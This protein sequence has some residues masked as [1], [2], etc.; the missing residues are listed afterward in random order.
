MVRRAAAAA[1]LFLFASAPAPLAAQY[2][3]QNKVQ[4]STFDFK[5]IQTDHF[6]VHYYPEERAAALD[7]ARMAERAYARLSRVLNHQFRER[8]PIIVYASH[9]DFQQTNATP[10]EVGEGTGGFTD[11]L[12]HRNIFPLTGSYY[13][14]EHVLM[15]EMVHQFQYDVWSRGRAGGGLATI[16]A[17]NPPLWFVEGMAEYLSI[18]PVDPNTAMWLRDA[19]IRGKVP[20]VEQLTGD[21]RI[22]PYRFGHALIAYIGERWG[23]EAVGAILTGT[24]S[25]GLEASVR[26]TL[27][28]SLEQLSE[29]WRDAVNR[30]YLPEIGRHAK[31][32]AIA[33]PLLT[34]ERSK[35]TLHLAP[36]LSPDGSAVAYFGEGDSYFVDLWL[37]DSTGATKRRLFKSTFSGDYETF[38]FLNSQAAWSP[39]GKYLAFAG[40][41]GATDEII[42]LDVARN[43]RVG[44]IRLDL[45]GV[46][47][48]TWSPDGERLVFTG[49]E[50]GLSDLF[51]VGRDGQGLR[52]LTNDKYAELHPVWSPDGRTIAFATDRGPGTDFETLRIGNFRIALFDLQTGGIRLLDG[53]DEGR[54]SSPQ[55]SPDG[56]SL[57]FI[58]DRSGV[59]NVFLYELADGGVYQLT[60]LYTGAQGYTPLSPVLSWAAKAD[61]L[62]FVYYEDTKFDVYTIDRPRDLKRRPWVPLPRDSA[63]T[64]ATVTTPEPAESSAPAAGAASAQVGDGGTIYRSQQGF[65]AAD[66]VPAVPVD[67]GLAPAAPVSIVALLDSAE[68]ALPDTGD[69]AHRDYRVRFTPDFVARPSIGYTRDNFGRGV[70][71]GSAISL[72]DILG[73]HQLIF[74]GYVNG[75][76]TEAQV[77]A[78]YANLKRRLNWAVGIQQDPYYFREPSQF[79]PGTDRPQDELFIENIRRLVV[80]S[81]FAQA[82]YPFSRFQRVE[83]GIRGANIDD[84][85]LQIVEPI[86]GQTGALVREPYL[87]ET[88]LPGVTYLQPHLGLVYDN[89]LFGYVGPLLGRRYR[90]EVAQTIGGW[91][92]TQ[93]T[94]DFRRYDKIV[95]PFTL[96]TRVLYFGR[97]GED[98]DEFRIFLG[99]PELVRGNT[100]GSYFRHEC[101]GPTD[102]N[103]QTGCAA[104]DQLIGTQI[105]VGSAE[106]RFPIIPGNF[107]LPV[108]G[109]VF[110]DIGFAWDANSTPKFSRGP[111]EDPLRIRTPLQAAGVSLRT[112]IMGFLVAKFD[113]SFPFNRPGVK[114]YWT[115]A[116]GPTF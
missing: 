70:F 49:Y 97:R 47:T 89:T 42:I 41:K 99:S 84:A 109:A 98:A 58:S 6:D 71:G 96:A 60:D 31:A 7:V 3:G 22:F 5:V 95:G 90:F 63:A 35:G 21:Y 68:L 25:G 82:A 77:L 33:T 76:I 65:R 38:R 114:G 53:M 30:R 2:F 54:N 88:N 10:G 19:A 1:L 55:W 87:L 61:R 108:E 92:Y 18:G 116:L 43:K 12:K 59:Q 67:S 29:Q 45:N 36:A 34:K 39:D 101:T 48:P 113:Y 93:L 86:D 91:R 106:L 102:L 79:D 56:S 62:A 57:A 100:S 32:S 83:A 16:V 23:D 46:T 27:G 78:A 8:K 15:H 81:V 105:A 111:D 9:S 44:R 74:A 110:Y 11:F 28:L 40:K 4:Y 52:R 75:R 94:A 104:L 50:G 112:N 107:G 103:T 51:V 13:E 85:R 20:T 37:A 72:S 69:L 73:N 115:I 80:R 24:L 26:R 14:N 66:E 17:V 64:L